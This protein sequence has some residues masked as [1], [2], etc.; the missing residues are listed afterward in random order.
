MPTYR[1]IGRQNLNNVF[2]KFLIRLFLYKYK[3]KKKAMLEKI[4]KEMV[5][6]RVRGM[7]K[8]F[9]LNHIENLPTEAEKNTLVKLLSNDDE[10]SQQIMDNL[11]SQFEKSELNEEV[12]K[13]ITNEILDTLQKNVEI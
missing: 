6:V 12:V 2:F 7:F 10:W 1:N 4:V 9:I 5:W 11:W 3:P 8:A 13:G